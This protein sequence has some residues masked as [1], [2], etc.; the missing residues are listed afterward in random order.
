MVVEAFVNLAREHGE[1]VSRG[2]ETKGLHKLWTWSPSWSSR[3]WLLCEPLTYMNRSGRSLAWLSRKH[4]LHPDQILVVHDELDLGLGTM[5]FKFGGGLAGHNG[6]R[7]IAQELGQREFYR[8]R[9]GIGRPD[10]G[11]DVV[12]YVLSSFRPEEKSELQAVLTRAAK[13]L[14]LFTEQGYQAAM[15]AFH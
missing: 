14:C 13:G 15:N 2:R 1:N 5:R 8:L 11:L 3:P 12:G 4:G 7:S 6:L 9:M 10:S